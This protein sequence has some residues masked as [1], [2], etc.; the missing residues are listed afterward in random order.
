MGPRMFAPRG[1]RSQA[2]GLVPLFSLLFPF[3]VGLLLLILY[4]GISCRTKQSLGAAIH[5]SDPY[6]N[7]PERDRCI[8]GISAR[9]LPGNHT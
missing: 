3:V 9:P 6:K 2:T 7:C 4:S 5:T 1:I 8:S